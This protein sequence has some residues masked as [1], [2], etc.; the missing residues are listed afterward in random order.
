[1][2]ILDISTA[3]DPALLESVEP[4]QLFWE[5]FYGDGQCS[6]FAAAQMLARV[7]K[8][9]KLIY[10]IL[11]SERSTNRPHPFAQF[12]GGR[13]GQNLLCEIGINDRV[14]IVS[15]ANAGYGR[16]VQVSDPEPWALSFADECVLLPP[17]EALGVAFDWITSGAL[18]VNYRLRPIE[19][20]ELPQPI[21]R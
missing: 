9:P 3:L 17:S 13:N 1:M 16:M 12:T 11:H 14:G 6:W 7:G 5:S 15:P 18:S 21:R 19:D 2:T 20:Y 10:L 8:D 4:D